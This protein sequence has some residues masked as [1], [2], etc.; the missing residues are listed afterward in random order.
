MKF[1][2][3]IEHVLPQILES[4]TQHPNLVIQAPPGA[5]KTTA[6]P[7]ALLDA[8][9]C[10]QQRIIMLEPRRLAARAAA[11]RMAEMLGEEVGQTV[12]YR[13]RL[14]KKI[15]ART[16]VEVVTEGM[17]T[18]LMQDDPALEGVAVVIFDEFHERH[19]HSDLGLALCLD[20]QT[21]LREDLR[22][23]AMSATLDAQ[24][25]ARLMNDAPI[26]SSEGR[27][28]P[29][30]VRYTDAQISD[31]KV[32]AAMVHCVV[33]ALQNTQG[34]VL[35]FL[36][37]VREIQRVEAA[38]KTRN[39][40]H[41]MR[42]AP[43]YGDLS[44][45]QQDQAIRPASDGKRRIVLA[46]NIA[47]TSLTIEGVAVV[48]DAGLARKLTFDT[49]SAMSRLIT[50]RISQASSVQRAGRAGRLGPGVCYRLWSAEAQ[51]RL[52]PFS[53]PEILEVDL[54]PLML[55]LAQW[56]VQDPD[57]L[58]WLTPP[59]SA[60]VAQARDLLTELNAID[61]N[62]HIT[63]H[64]RAMHRLGFHPRLAHMMLQ[65]KALGV[66]YLACELA[67][68]LSE[69]DILRGPTATKDCD[70]RTRLMIWRATVNRSNSAGVRDTNV[71]RYL[72][73]QIKDQAERWAQHLGVTRQ[74]GE[75]THFL[76]ILVA[77]A[78]PD[79]VA[80]RRGGVE[81]RYLVANGRGATF[82]RP[83]SLAQENLIAIAQLDAGQRE[84]SIFLAAE[85]E[86]DA[87]FSAFAPHIICS[88]HVEWNE[89]LNTVQAKRVWRY[90]ALS[91]REQPLAEVPAELRFQALIEG[92]RSRG[93]A[94]LPWSPSLREWQARVM[95]L[96]R[97]AYV[98][99][100][101]PA[102]W[103]DVS[104]TALAAQLE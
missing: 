60:N 45:A 25:V 4:L 33:H 57:R 95:L 12:G 81:P 1:S 31:T 8:A 99:R 16:R 49:N 43:L 14:D 92:V 76:G 86:T 13:V 5:G 97:S 89:R 21:N 59:P 53:A 56:G 23:I 3:P 44:K 28:F 27:A 18:R 62:G 74:Q 19:L 79:R 98:L 90:K 69:R 75:D 30:E 80:Q 54:A 51:Q 40:C 100:D 63:A 91:L 102:E 96:K 42:I 88:D 93:V 87:F 65:G 104:D 6:V 72:C 41:D 103:P 94:Q 48:V 84:A 20:V 85:L 24:P 73:N 82:V 29:V 9:W 68:L 101:E 67:A 36:P 34:D 61:K 47:E 77:H 11:A 10:A 17:L 58:R 52:L 26:V 46:T 35:A 39:E 22:L 78:Y 71:D 66:G 50:T 15:S 2:L 64:G 38:L 7:L 37:G 70:I 83:E 55:E 32:D